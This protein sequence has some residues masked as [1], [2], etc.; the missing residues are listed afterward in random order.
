MYVKQINITSRPFSDVMMADAMFLNPA[1]TTTN[2]NNN[3]N[4]SFV[5]AP[6]TK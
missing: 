5:P 4:I 6:M 1:I 3:N 2:N